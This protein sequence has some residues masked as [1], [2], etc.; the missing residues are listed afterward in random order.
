MELIAA[1]IIA[2][3]IAMMVYMLANLIV[4]AVSDE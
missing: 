4:K 3:A 2:A 1:P